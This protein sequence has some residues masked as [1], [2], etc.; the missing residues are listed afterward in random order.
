MITLRSVDDGADAVL[1]L[2][3]ANDPEAR[4]Q[5]FN[6]ELITLGTHLRWLYGR[7]AD[8][9]CRLFIAEDEGKPVG[10]VRLQRQGIEATVSITVA[11]VMRNQGF[12]KRILQAMTLWVCASNFCKTLIAEIKLDNEAS[13]ALFRGAGY[14][15]EAMRF[16]LELQKEEETHA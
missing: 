2:V 3:W 6:T 13:N 9:N 12:G 5:S 14:Q 16:R 10:T 15:A 7:M 11:P 4:R 8:P 1:L